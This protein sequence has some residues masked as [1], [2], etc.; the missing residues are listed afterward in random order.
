MPTS[1][2]NGSVAAEVQ[3]VSGKELSN[4]RLA[5]EISRLI[6]SN[7]ELLRK[8]EFYQFRVKFSFKR[9]NDK[10]SVNW[11]VIASNEHL[12]GVNEHRSGKKFIYGT[13]KNSSKFQ[14]L[15]DMIITSQTE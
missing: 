13:A 15:R 12:I 14:I 7:A 2:D 8:T 3:M 6:K 5:S 9:F 1:T 11:D 4:K 10:Y